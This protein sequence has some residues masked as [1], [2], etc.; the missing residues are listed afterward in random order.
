MTQ[1]AEPYVSVVRTSADVPV[2]NAAQKILLCAQMDTAGTAAD[3]ALQ[4]N[5]LSLADAQALFGADSPMARMWAAADSIVEG[6]VQIDCIAKD[7]VAGNAREVTLTFTGNVSQSGSIE[8]VAGSEL[9]GRVKVAVAAGDTPT[10]VATAIAAAF[11]ALTTNFGF[12]VASALGVVTFTADTQGVWANGYGFTVDVGKTGTSGAVAEGQ[13]GT[14]EPTLTGIL[15]PITSTNRRYQGVVW[16]FSD[17]AIPVGVLDGRFD[18]D[19][20][21]LD[22]VLFSALVDTHANLLTALA[23][24]DYNSAS[25]AALM[26]EDESLTVG[27]AVVH[28][29]SAQ[30]EPP[31]I[32]LSWFAA[33]RAL[34]L[35][36]GATVSQY[37][38]TSASRDQRGGSALASLPYFNTVLPDLP[39]MRPGRGFTDA[40]KEQ[41][42]AAGGYVMG[43]NVTGDQGIVGEVVMTYL[44]DGAGN[45][46]PTYQFLNYVDTTSQIQEYF[47]NNCKKRFAQARLTEGEVKRNRDQVNRKV[48]NAFLVKLYRDL[49][50]VDFVLTQDGEEALNFFRENIDTQLTL[51]S[52][53]ISTAFKCPIVTQTRRIDVTIKIAFTVEG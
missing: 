26:D 17:P 7:E 20:R 4:E 48:F 12:T 29:G 38:T 49:A 3:G 9:N 24:A 35:T 41:L 25:H 36:T 37:V 43:E 50:G 33:V 31:E 2:A 8:V 52:G 11:N 13:A 34:R 19:N 53:L 47:F 18:A 32:K 40:E 16:G 23:G 42:K 10:Q 45:P 6:R 5:V 21:V 46:D 39:P 27:G 51:V 28:I 1:V 14:G 30:L 22:G 44:T 15:D